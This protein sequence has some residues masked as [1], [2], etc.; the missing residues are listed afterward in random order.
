M[1]AELQTYLLVAVIV[2]IAATIQGSTG[3]GFNMFA[4]PIVALI[5][6][7]FLPGPLL[8]LA[9]MVSIGVMLREF[10]AIDVQES[11]TRWLDDCLR[12]SWPAIRWR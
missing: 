5:E 1:P 7:A 4:A 12:H 11:A 8:M 6:P 9:A 3:I 2:A 10:R